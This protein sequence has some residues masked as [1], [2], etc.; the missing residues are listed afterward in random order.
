MTLIQFLIQN[1]GSI[2]KSPIVK[3]CLLIIKFSIGIEEMGITKKT[4][5]CGGKVLSKHFCYTP[6]HARKT[7]GRLSFTLPHQK[8]QSDSKSSQYQV[9]SWGHFDLS[10]IFGCL[11]L[12]IL[13][14]HITAAIVQPCTMRLQHRINS[15]T[16]TMLSSNKTIL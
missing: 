5:G 1:P 7:I 4:T 8:L 16:P 11:L 6:Y 14:V 15:T 9:S 13:A 2:Q 10:C 12:N 3:Y